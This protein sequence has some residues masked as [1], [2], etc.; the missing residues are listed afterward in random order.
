MNKKITLVSAFVLTSLGL[1]AQENDSIK[2]LNE[3]V[4]ST[5]KFNL[6][7]EKSGKVIVKITT[8]ELQKRSGQSVAN[9]LNT[10]AGVEVNGNLGR[11][12]KNLDLYIRGGRSQQNLIMI[13]GIPVTDAS[14]I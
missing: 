6:P 8:E 12:G 4:V 14:G 13:D 7:K 11:N 3:V 5:S 1:F 9:V 10:V 2:N